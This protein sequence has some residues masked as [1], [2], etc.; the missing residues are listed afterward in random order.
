[1]EWAVPGPFWSVPLARPK[2]LPVEAMPPGSVSEYR[3]DWASTVAAQSPSAAAM[4]RLLASLALA[5]RG[6]E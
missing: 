5:R 6:A 2:V 4:A 3:N 1:M